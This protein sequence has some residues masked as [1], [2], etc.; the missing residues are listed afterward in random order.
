VDFSTLDV[1]MSALVLN[2]SRG[3][4]FLQSD[5]PLPLDTKVDL[6]LPVPG[7]GLIH[8]TGRVA[9]NHDLAD[10]ESHRPRG[11]GIQFLD[12]PEADRELL[13]DYIASL[14]TYDGQFGGH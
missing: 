13:E 12:L 9:W 8:A 14:E 3:G 10:Q 4:V 1:E 2:V 6:V 5:R 7:L 11:S